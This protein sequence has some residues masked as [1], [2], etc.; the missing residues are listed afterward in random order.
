MQLQT[1]D[2]SNLIAIVVLVPNIFKDY[3]IFESDEIEDFDVGLREFWLKTNLNEINT[4]KRWEVF[5]RKPKE[6][7]GCLI[8]HSKQVLY[9]KPKTLNGE[10]DEPACYMYRIKHNLDEYG[11]KWKPERFD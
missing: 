9:E 6:Q 11:I 2:Q 4:M 5:S 1:I 3:I 8:T 10:I 7:E